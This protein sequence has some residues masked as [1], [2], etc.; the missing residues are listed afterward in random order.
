MLAIIF[1]GWKLT[2]MRARLCSLQT[3]TSTRCAAPSKIIRGSDSH[4]VV[5]IEELQMSENA[6]KIE[7]HSRLFAFDSEIVMIYELQ[8]EKCR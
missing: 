2:S 7:C 3:G 4:I 6:G 5:V 1:G 8:V